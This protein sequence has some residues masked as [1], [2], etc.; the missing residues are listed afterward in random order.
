VIK[1]VTDFVEGKLLETLDDAG[2]ERPSF[3]F[4]ARA[5]SD[6]DAPPRITWVPV[7]GNHDKARAAAADQKQTP[8]HIWTRHVVI[9]AHIWADCETTA[10]VLMGHLVAT[11]QQNLG[12]A[13]Y[14]M[15]G[16]EWAASDTAGSAGIKLVV[17]IQFHLPLVTET[18]PLVKPPMTVAI[19]SATIEEAA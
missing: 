5:L 9:E 10:E 11:L 8:K 19:P 6:A 13:P 15:V 17:G 4:G 14:S 7:R 2:V 18:L 1:E 3:G 16:E 12:S